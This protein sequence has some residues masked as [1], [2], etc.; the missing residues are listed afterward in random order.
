MSEKFRTIVAMPEEAA[1]KLRKFIEKKKPAKY[2]QER[3]KQ[4]DDAGIKVSNP[5]FRDTAAVIGLGT[6]KWSAWLA[7]GGSQF[8]LTLA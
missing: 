3:R 2:I 5:V 6:M 4:K 1:K 8:L 7:T